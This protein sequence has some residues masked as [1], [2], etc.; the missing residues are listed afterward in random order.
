MKFASPMSSPRPSPGSMAGFSSLMPAHLHSEME[1]LK[2]LKNKLEMKEEREE[3]S[4][5]D[6]DVSLEAS[7]L[8]EQF[9][10]IGTEMVITKSGR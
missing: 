9:H 5:T 8:W 3:A 6:P 10:N 7:N 2:A 4:D 1:S